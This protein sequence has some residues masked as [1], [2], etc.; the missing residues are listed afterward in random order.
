MN[1]AFEQVVRSESARLYALCFRLTGNAEEAED[2]CH[3]VFLRALKAFDRFEGRSQ[4]G[5]WLYRITLNLWKNKIR[6]K[7]KRSFL[8][9]LPFRS[10]DPDEDETI[11]PAGPDV[12]PETVFEKT[13]STHLL[14][15]ALM[16]LDP[17]ERQMI[18]LRDL[19]DYS[20]D[21]IAEMLNLPLGTVKSRLA[22]ARDTLRLKLIPLLKRRGEWND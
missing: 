19:D 3:D 14:Q 21:A 2:L 12:T 20:Y 17:E 6:G 5:T 13:E 7:A 18:V 9:L 4:V 11:D 15:E 22:R 8:R 16:K 1:E 10:D